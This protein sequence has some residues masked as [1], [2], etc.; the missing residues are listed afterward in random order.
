MEVVEDR[1]STGK[2]VTTRARIKGLV[3]SFFDLLGMY[4]AYVDIALRGHVGDVRRNVDIL[5]DAWK[6]RCAH[7]SFKDLPTIDEE[8]Y[9]SP[10]IAFF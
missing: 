2:R 8:T 10:V 1:I 7:T 6:T 9:H 5:S 4:M 3:F